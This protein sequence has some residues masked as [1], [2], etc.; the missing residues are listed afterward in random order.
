MVLNEDKSLQLQQFSIIFPAALKY[1]IF[2][3][4]HQ[5]RLTEQLIFS[6]GNKADEQQTFEILSDIVA[7]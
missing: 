5:R 1:C 3:A 4:S 6:R 7:C 2:C